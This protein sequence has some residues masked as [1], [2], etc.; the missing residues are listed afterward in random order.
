MQSVFEQKYRPVEIIVVDDGST[1]GTTELMAQYG[2]KIRYIWHENVGVAKNRTIACKYAKGEYIAFIDDDDLMPSDRIENLYDAISKSPSAV[3]AVGDLVVI[4]SNGHQVGVRW[5]P[6][7][8]LSDSLPVMIENGY[9]AVL[10]PTIPANPN[11]ILFKKSA[12]H[13][14]GWFDDQ[15][16]TNSE[17]KDFFARLATLGP[18]VYV[19]K[20]VALYRRGHKSLTSPN[21]KNLFDRARLFEKHLVSCTPANKKLRKRLQQRLLNLL[22]NHCMHDHAGAFDPYT[23]KQ[24]SEFEKTM[25]RSLGMVA[26]LKYYFYKQIKMPIKRRFQKL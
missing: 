20:V 23:S 13:E 8:K 17:D 10:W 15:F 6:R 9:E 16:L 18:V 24:F 7:G 12:G 14:I 1:D 25:L 5:L 2:D 21:K 26:V 22:K 4:D 19:P 11:T 3:Y